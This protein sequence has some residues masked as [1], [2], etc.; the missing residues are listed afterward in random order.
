MAKVV[1][2]VR[3]DNGEVTAVYPQLKNRHGRLVCY[4]HNGQNSLCTVDWVNEQDQ[5]S[6]NEYAPLKRE[7]EAAG[8]VLKIS[9]SKNEL[10]NTKKKL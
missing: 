9:N 4:S 8:L 2:F 5:A 7:L 1:R 3:E 10:L 6:E